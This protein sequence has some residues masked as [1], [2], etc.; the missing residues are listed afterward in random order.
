M[1]RWNFMG[2]M[3]HPKVRGLDYYCRMDTDSRITSKVLFAPN[4]CRY[5]TLDPQLTAGAQPEST[6]YTS[7]R[8][9]PKPAP[10]N[11]QWDQ[12][13]LQRGHMSRT[14]Q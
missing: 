14:V 5:H 8:P 4:P 6:P 10:H 2:M 12:L 11:A 1:C 7:P 9:E 3:Q 13:R